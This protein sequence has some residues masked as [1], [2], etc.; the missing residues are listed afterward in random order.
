MPSADSLPD[1]T[2]T[3][4]D[5][6][7]VRQLL[8]EGDGSQEESTDDIEIETQLTK[9]LESL[10]LQI[11]FD[12]ADTLVDDPAPAEPPKA[13]KAVAPDEAMAPQKSSE[14]VAAQKSSE[15]L[16]AQKSSEAVAAQKSSEALAAQKSSEAVDEAM[17]PQKSSQAL[18][19]QKSSEAP[20][21]QKSSEA[22][23]PQKSSEAMA[24]QKSSEAVAPQKSSE[25]VLF[26]SM[27]KKLVEKNADMAQMLMRP[28]TVDFEKLLAEEA[29]A[30][31]MPPPSYIPVKHEPMSQDVIKKT[32]SEAAAKRGDARRIS[33]PDS[34]GPSCASCPLA[35]LEAYN[36]CLLPNGRVDRTKL[37]RMFDDWARHGEDW[38]ETEVYAQWESKQL[39]RQKESC[40][41]LTRKEI[42]SRYGY[43]EEQV[44]KLC[45]HKESTGEWRWHPD[46][47]GDEEMK[48]FRCWD[49]ALDEDESSHGRSI[50]FNQRG[51]GPAGAAAALRITGPDAGAG[52]VAVELPGGGRGKGGGKNKGKAGG[53]KGK[54]KGEGKGDDTPTP[55]AKT[56]LQI[57]KAVIVQANA[58]LLEISG[59]GHKLQKAG[60]DHNLA[61]ALT[62]S[63]ARTSA[64]ISEER[65]K[66]E[67]A[68]ARG[69]DG[70]ELRLL[71]EAV[72]KANDDF[73]ASSA[74]GIQEAALA[75]QQESGD[76]CSD[77]H[78]IQI[79]IKDVR[80]RRGRSTLRLP[81]LMPHEVFD[82]LYATDR[83]QRDQEEI[84]KFW[85]HV[86][87]HTTW[88]KDHIA[89]GHNPMSIYGD[90]A[91]YNLAGDK[92]LLIAMS[93]VLARE[94]ISLS[95][96]VQGR[97]G[98][99]SRL[100]EVAGELAI[101]QGVSLLYGNESRWRLSLL[102]HFPERS[103]TDFNS[104]VRWASANRVQHS[105][106]H[107]TAG[108][109]TRDPYPSLNLKAWNGRVFVVFLEI[110]LN[111][112]VAMYDDDRELELA[113]A[114]ATCIAVWFDRSE[115]A[116]RYLTE[117]EA[118]TI[119][120][121]GLK[122]IAYYEALARHCIHADVARFKVI[123]KLH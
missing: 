90:E 61:N 59:F 110:C 33:E 1:Q 45:A 53:K 80:E 32:L 28:D 43:T 30:Q 113:A 11:D 75:M 3:P 52:V 21:P 58:N 26:Q 89:Q 48:L 87:D 10:S 88:G 14:A 19:P 6:R 39:N 12:G 36:E 27:L 92:V 118:D 22:L 37:N 5:V 79:P 106:N 46:F 72:A 115:R 112:A 82:Y 103:V 2:E 83:L 44:C 49:S 102:R 47:P 8:V 60:C 81:F 57:A 51:A 42:K 114:A 29:D 105:Q 93:P 9:D 18:A 95:G 111:A 121:A 56:P 41:W 38:G 122:F 23:A 66:L 91:R 101:Y 55:K 94:R 100:L 25:A 84:D 120:E 108:M 77:I 70:D 69:V 50:S 97:L 34:T 107:L 71:G 78:H 13:N 17:A 76:H 117:S 4:A 65:Q 40:R 15:A 54:N 104:I 109:I 73:K 64:Q 62:E 116:S 68:I 74:K 99:A 96:R 24:P 63:M 98:L 86:R 7:Y 85:N 20:A 119:C 67:A 123:P 35:V 31:S 16:A